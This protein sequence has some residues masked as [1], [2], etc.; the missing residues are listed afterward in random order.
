VIGVE[1]SPIGVRDF[2]DNNGLKAAHSHQG[3]FE[4]WQGDG[5][6]LLCGDVFKL[7]ASDLDGVVAMYDRAALIALPPEIRRE[8]VDHLREILPLGT[9]ALLVTID[10]PQHQ[11]G[12]P[13]FSVAD[14]E[15]CTL[16]SE[17]FDLEKIVSEDALA[18]NGR[19][20]GRV[21]YLN[22]RAYSLN[23]V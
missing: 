1:L 7:T 12:G 20:T 21:D 2:F 11:H 23:R 4:R 9:K 6:M 3:E 15:V 18:E 19:F 8:Y 17:G 14:D 16:F 13:P 10:Y 22:E 5:V